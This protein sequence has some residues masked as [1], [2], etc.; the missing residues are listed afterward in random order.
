VT[1]GTIG[2]VAIRTFT[3]TAGQKLTLTVSGNSIAGA[4]LTIRDPNGST[5]AGLFASGATAFRDVFTLPTTG[6]YTITV[7]PRDVLTG[8]LTYTMNAVPDDVG[9]TAIGTPTTVTI[10][11]IGEVAVRSFPATAGQ[12]LTMTVT[13]NSIAGADLTVRDPNGNT[14]ATLFA[15][16]ATAFRDVFTLPTTGTYTITVDPRDVLTGS[17]T[18]TMNA[19]PD[20]TGST[21]IGTPTTV[22]IGTIGE[23]AI[24]TF[25]ATAGQSVTLSVSGNAIPGVDLTIRNPSGA[26]VATLFASGATATRS[27][28]TLPVTGTYTITVD[29]RDQLVGSLTF[30]LAQN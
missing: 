7:D 29:P 18:Y 13:G 21:A 19:V 12:K 1:I 10:G 24:R 8:A 3:A 15:S 6:T 16:A 23:V 25:T 22:T 20:N 5:V 9:S 26:T 30:T 4:D 27:A 17:L 28:F 14:V 2:E 11:T